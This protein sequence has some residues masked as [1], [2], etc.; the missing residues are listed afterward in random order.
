MVYLD[1]NIELKKVIRKLGINYKHLLNPYNV[2][3]I[4]PS[5]ELQR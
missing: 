1:R 4:V 2:L 5:A 3:E